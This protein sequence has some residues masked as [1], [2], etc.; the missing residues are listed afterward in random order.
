MIEEGGKSYRVAVWYLQE[1][2]LIIRDSHHTCKVAN[3]CMN[4]RKWVE[5][6]ERNKAGLLPFPAV[7]RITSDDERKP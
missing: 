4:V 2:R 6:V 5:V 1:V 7:P 3:K